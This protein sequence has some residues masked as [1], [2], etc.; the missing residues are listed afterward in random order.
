[1][2]SLSLNNGRSVTARVGGMT[3]ALLL[4][5]T[6]VCAQGKEPTYIADLVIYHG[7]HFDVSFAQYEREDIESAPDTG[8]PSK[9][10]IEESAIEIGAVDKPYLGQGDRGLALKV[11]RAFCAHYDL[12]LN[13]KPKSDMQYDGLWIFYDLCRTE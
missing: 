2:N 5:A 4:A 7:R 6:G 10:W 3:L 12:T 1:M 11:A 13:S 8:L 9:I